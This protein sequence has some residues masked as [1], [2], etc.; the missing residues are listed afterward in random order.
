VWA[1]APDNVIDNF[2]YLNIAANAKKSARRGLTLYC[3]NAAGGLFRRK[4]R[5]S[6][7]LPLA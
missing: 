6:P 4:R 1:G 2:V 3:W 5:P 7:A